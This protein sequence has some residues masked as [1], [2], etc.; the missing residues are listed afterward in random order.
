M[1]RDNYERSQYEYNIK[2]WFGFEKW[3]YRI[4]DSI[5]YK[6]DYMCTNISIRVF[7][8]FSPWR[9]GMI[10]DDHNTAGVITND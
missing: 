1:M 3:S 5:T 2:G 4:A 7:N 8:L 10:R 6:D 9:L